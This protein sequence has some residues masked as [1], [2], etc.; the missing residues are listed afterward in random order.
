M[1]ISRRGFVRTV[2][3]G[4]TGVLS[5]PF[6]TGRGR[7]AA[8]FEITGGPL[9]ADDVIKIS[10]NENARGPGRS[11][12]AAIEDAMTVRMGRG[13]P[14]D[15]TGDLVTTIAQTFGVEEGNVLVGTGSGGILQG[16]TQAFCTDR[17]LVTAAPT[18]GTPES[19][20]R[21]MGADM[22]IVPVDAS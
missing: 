17:P 3:L 14:P 15:H 9:L 19:T 22:R 12:F 11:V 7:E 4:A 5:A 6:I 10:S 1:S 2:G 21:R 13:Y 16:G 20:A 8:A 18:Y